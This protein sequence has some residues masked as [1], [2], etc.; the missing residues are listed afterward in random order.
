MSEDISDQESVESG[1]C[2]CSDYNRDISWFY[3][4]RKLERSY[5]RF[6]IISEKTNN[7]RSIII[8]TPL[9]KKRRQYIFEKKMS[10]NN[11]NNNNSN[12]K[13]TS[14]LL[15]NS[16]VNQE[17]RRKNIIKITN[18]FST[19]KF[20][21]KDNHN[22]NKKKAHKINLI[23]HPPRRKKENNGNLEV[24]KNENK[25]K[26]TVLRHKLRN[27]TSAN[28]I[29]SNPPKDKDNNNI[30]PKKS[31]FY[32]N[33]VK[34][35]EHKNSN[36]IDKIELTNYKNSN[37][38]K[39]NFEMHRSPMNF[40]K[41][42]MHFYNL[43]RTEKKEDEKIPKRNIINSPKEFIS[44]RNK[45]KTFSRLNKSIGEKIDENEEEKKYIIDK[46]NNDINANLVKSN[47]TNKRTTTKHKVVKE[48]QNI[49]LKPGET[50]KPKS[51][52]KRQL[53]PHTTIVRNEFGKESIVTENTLLTTVIVNELV[54]PSKN[55]RNKNPQDGQLVK[56]YITKIYKTEIETLS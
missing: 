28:E 24:K 22:I 38:N 37:N 54:E 33:N 32:P 36:P 18:S 56:Q 52:T 8:K 53:K 20:D 55:R 30:H 11:D 27:N 19:K 7:N 39:I 17:N 9:F 23:E 43:N 40:T 3:D 45:Y 48:T 29:N 34:D 5:M 47:Y 25:P 51:I 14:N 41:N 42:R 31:R 50:I 12:Y 49:I 16:F 35:Y 1:S 4:S 21:S 15:N 10:E 6:S 2:T 13:S 26:K 46:K 44:P